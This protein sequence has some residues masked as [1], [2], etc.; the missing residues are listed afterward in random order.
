MVDERLSTLLFTCDD[1]NAIRASHVR[2]FLSAKF[3]NL[4]WATNLRGSNERAKLQFSQK[5]ITRKV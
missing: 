5:K 1:D 4:A 3:S 2:N